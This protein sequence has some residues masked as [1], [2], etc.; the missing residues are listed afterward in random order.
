MKVNKLRG[1]QGFASM[2]KEK[3]LLAASKGGKR[4]HE[5]HAAHEWNSDEARAAG[6]IGGRARPKNYKNKTSKK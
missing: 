2:K 1:L 3:Q 6:K 4:A 5:L